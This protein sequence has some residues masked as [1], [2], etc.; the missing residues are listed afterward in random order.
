MNLVWIRNDIRLDDNPALFK[1]CQTGDKVKVIYCSTPKQWEIHNEAPVKLGLRSDLLSDLSA[2]LAE[3]GIEFELLDAQ[4]F[5]DLP[6]LISNYC[7]DNKITDLWFN[8]DYLID[9]NKRDRLTVK[10]LNENNIKS[11]ICQGDVIFSDMIFNKEGKPYK[12]FTP[13]YK[14]NLKQLSHGFPEVYPKPS[15]IA[16]PIN[17]NQL[18][19]KLPNSTEY[20]SDIWGGTEQDALNSL[21]KFV[22]N[23]VLQYKKERDYPSINATSL[24]S[25]Y[26][27]S[28][29]ISPRRCGKAIFEHKQVN[30]V[31]DQWMSELGWR[32]FYR[33]L[34]V[35]FPKVVRNEPFQ[36]Y[37][38]NLKWDVSSELFQ[39]WVDGKTGFPLV[40]AAMRQLKQTGWMH[41]RLRMLTACFLAKLMM[42]NWQDGEKYFMENLIDGDFASN[43]GGWQWG[44]STGCDAAPYFR[45]FNPTTQSQKFDAEGK[46]IRK[47]VP[48]LKL[49]SDKEIHQPSSMDR[50][51]LNYPEPVIDYPAARLEIV[52]RFKAIK[53]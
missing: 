40:D 19:I 50:R 35:N 51:K 14:A 11:H 27:A 8:E 24:L 29:A 10:K 48:E 46:F 22:A 15:P 31:D 25:T 17:T 7:L 1:A 39:A 21:E 6:E 3:L 20:R 12:V 13:W 41:N 44:A 36:E 23:K 42:I 5:A 37:T 45:I 52:K 16:D 28:G 33:Y 30:W 4:I 32:D 47:F 26:L 49:L 34:A 53:T 38:K 43:N 2:N 9:E 18:N